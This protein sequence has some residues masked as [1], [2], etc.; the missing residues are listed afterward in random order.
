MFSTL[1]AKENEKLDAAAIQKQEVKKLDLKL[2]S[3]LMK[4]V[5]DLILDDFNNA[6]FVFFERPEPRDGSGPAWTEPAYMGVDSHGKLVIVRYT[7]SK[8]TCEP[9][10]CRVANNVPAILKGI[11][12]CRFLLDDAPVMEIVKL[13]ESAGYHYKVHI[14]FPRHARDSSK[15]EYFLDPVEAVKCIGESIA[16]YVKLSK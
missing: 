7:D 13:Q 9:P 11:V 1:V 12:D 2:K 15:A 6:G 3:I 8:L 5:T 14:H 4:Q 10:V 16:K